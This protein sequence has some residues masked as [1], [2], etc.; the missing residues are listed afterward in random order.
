M[1][2]LSYSHYVTSKRRYTLMCA[3]LVNVGCIC[4]LGHARR[5]HQIFGPKAANLANIGH[6]RFKPRIPSLVL[7]FRNET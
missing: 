4:L 7:C 5:S 2:I 6:K 1:T 3:D